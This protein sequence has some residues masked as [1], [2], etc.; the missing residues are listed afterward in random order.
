M[1]VKQKQKRSF[2]HSSTFSTNP[3]YKA[4]LSFSNFSSSSF[5]LIHQGFVHLIH[6]E[7]QTSTL[8]KSF[9]LFC[10][11]YILKNPFSAKSLPTKINLIFS[12]DGLLYEY[13][14]RFNPIAPKT[15]TFFVFI[16]CCF[17]QIFFGSSLD[18]KNII[19]SKYGKDNLYK[20]T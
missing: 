14:S 6:Q 18:F 5:F 11:F 10:C 16:L 3:G 13:S 19:F 12:S 4:L 7:L 17:Y 8:G 20:K 15:S 2:I 1:T 9:L